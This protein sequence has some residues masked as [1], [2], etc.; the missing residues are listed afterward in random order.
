MFKE[1]ADTWKAVCQCIA[2][3]CR[4]CDIN[5]AHC[6]YLIPICIN[7][8]KKGDVLTLPV[9]HA[10]LQDNRRNCE[11]FVDSNGLEIF[12]RPLLC[13]TTCVQLLAALVQEEPRVSKLLQT[14]S[15]PEQLIALA[16]ARGKFTEV[17]FL[18]NIFS[19]LNELEDVPK[20]EN[21]VDKMKIIDEHEI[22]PKSKFLDESK[23]NSTSKLLNNV[24]REMFIWNKENNYITNEQ[25][26]HKRP[27]DLENIKS[28]TS[29]YF[30]NDTAQKLPKKNLPFDDGFQQNSD[31][32]LPVDNPETFKA[33]SK[34]ASSF[35]NNKSV[36]ERRQEVPLLYM[37]NQSTNYNMIDTE[38]RS[39]KVHRTT[40]DKSMSHLTRADRTGDYDV[41]N[42]KRTSTPKS[43]TRNMSPPSKD[44]KN[45]HGRKN[46][47]EHVYVHKHNIALRTTAG[48]RRPR[49]RQRRSAPAQTARGRSVSARIFGAL[50]DTCATVVNAIKDMIL[51]RRRTDTC[52]IE[53]ATNARRTSRDWS[54]T[55]FMKP[56]DVA[57]RSVR[58]KENDHSFADIAAEDRNSI[59]SSTEDATRNENICRTCNDTL[60]LKRKLAND[61]YLKETLRKLKIGI[62]LYGCD[63]KKMSKIMWRDETSMTPRVLYNLYRKLILK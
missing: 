21:F 32:C 11:H 18:C 54:F 44:N 5:Q 58:T 38:F 51:L 60:L 20:N 47:D 17:I 41:F 55:Y 26:S 9:L 27:K 37:R 50:N 35:I 36:R 22:T 61:D 53:E 42:P 34:L 56:R 4:G 6:S 57:R 29:N 14:S 52:K 46:F 30:S 25:R 43:R 31:C 15:V 13:E 33:K 7:K 10:L 40:V 49:R 3:C 24:M 28:A 45:V 16:Q 2:E 23:L 8:C 48:A 19:V 59:C 12:A 1:H 62:N 63:F 39:D